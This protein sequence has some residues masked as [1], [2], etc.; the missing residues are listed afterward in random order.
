MNYKN[1]KERLE[2]VLAGQHDHMFDDV[3]GAIHCMSRPRV[4]AV[5]NACVSAM[6]PGELYVEVGTYQGGS[7]I[8]ALRGNETHAVGVDSFGEF[9]TTNSLERTTKNFETFGVLDRV[10]LHNMGFQEYFAHCPADLHIQV[11]YYD[12]AHDYETQLAG[13]EAGWSHLRTGSIILV[14]DFLYPEVNR[15]INQ[16]IANH[17][18]EIKILVAID[19]MNDVDAVWWN[20]VIALRV[21]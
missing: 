2:E 10:S 20:G 12:G 18:N 3:L 15:A 19:S 4:Y 21:L 1:L 8:S 11:Y 17:V 14:D 13:M 5:L 9:Q 7:L 6:D 16:F